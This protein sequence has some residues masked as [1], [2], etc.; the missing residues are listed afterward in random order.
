MLKD[1]TEGSEAKHIIVFAVPM[2]IGNVFQQLYN[3]VDAAVVGQ[4]VGPDALAAVGASFPVSFLMIAAVMGLTMGSAILISQLYGARR[5]EEMRRAVSTLLLFSLFSSIALSV[6]GYFL[7]VPVLRLIRT[8]DE[9]LVNASVFLKISF[10]GLVFAFAYNIFSAIL[11]SLGD[12]KTP[13]YFLVLS[14][15]LNVAL[16]L[17]FV[18]I[19][20][21]G[22][23]GV[24]WATVISQGVAAVGTASFI[25]IRNIEAL[26]FKLS[27]LVFDRVL[28]SKSLKLGIPSAVQQ[29]VLSMGF[30]LIQGL[31]NSFGAVTMAAIAAASRIE[32][33]TTLPNMNIGMAAA[34]FTGQNMGAGKIDR[35]KKGYRSAVFI[36]LAFSVVTSL[37]VYFAGPYMIQ[38]FVKSTE[39]E[40]IRQGREYLNVI[41]YFLIIFGLMYGTNSVLRGAGDVNISML[42]TLITLGVRIAAGYTMKYLGMGPEAIWWSLP[43]GWAI[44]LGIALWRYFTGAWEKKAVARADE[45]VPVK[46][47]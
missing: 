22:V 29:T 30:I 41:S 16:D 8:P 10:T 5:M 44:G 13:L 46:E 18:P 39:T 26:K 43:I 2:L 37:I 31:V 34:T 47:S 24:A 42:S 17:V 28:F 7:S 21:W 25:Y 6:L 1:M 3:I 15:A 19:F 33:I 35:V 32:S 36:I 11:R 14:V 20:H 27:E 4:F 40:I 38:I 12:S 9:V 23:A 45:P